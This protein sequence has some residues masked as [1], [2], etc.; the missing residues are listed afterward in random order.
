MTTT[1]HY[2]G[3]LVSPGSVRTVYRP[4][5][6][7]GR[8]H[9]GKDCQ[10]GDNVVIDV[11]EECVIGDRCVIPDNTRIEGRR[12]T[13]GSD[14]FVYAWDWK[15]L[16]IGRGRRDDEHAILTIGDRC[17]LHD[18]RIDLA[19]EVAIGNDVGLSPEVTI[20]THGY[21]QSVL[22]GFPCSYEPVTVKDGAIIG[23]RS[24]LLPGALV[25]FNC[26]VGAHSVVVGA[27]EDETVNAGVPAKYRH[28]VVEPDLGWKK[29]TFG[30]IADEYVASLRYRGHKNPMIVSDYPRIELVGHGW[31]DVETRTCHGDEDAYTDDLRWFCFTRGIR[32]YTRRPFRKLG[33]VV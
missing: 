31:V 30:K 11:A 16:D 22:D 17:T 20:Y 4:L 29:A 3:M 23:Y 33:R 28:R 10:I 26:V 19:R 15:R 13:I 2:H 12:V 18:N 14:C 1:D 21:W 32:I 25:G 6:K 9:A 24:T 27:L 7:S 8:F 5:V